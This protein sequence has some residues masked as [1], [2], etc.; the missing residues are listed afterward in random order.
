[1]SN[2]SLL[3]PVF[4]QVA[5]TFVLMIAVGRSRVGAIKR[6]EVK[7]RDIALGQ[8]DPW[9]DRPKAIARSFQ[10]QFE[11]P[12]LFYAV[13]GFALATRGVTTMLVGLAWAYVLLRLLHAAIHTGSNN[14]NQRF[15]VFVLSSAVLLAMWVLFGLHVAAMA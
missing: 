6:R 2:A 14:I 13:V 9:P 12:M 7:V 4:V 11:M 3:F 5:L 1:M 8:T 10:N 15:G